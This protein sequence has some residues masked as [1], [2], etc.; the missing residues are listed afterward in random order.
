MKNLKEIV[1]GTKED[2]EFLKQISILGVDPSYKR[3]GFSVV[4]N[5]K[6][7]HVDS[8]DFKSGTYYMDSGSKKLKRRAIR[9]KVE[10]LTKKYNP[11]AIVIERVR[12]FSTSYVSL[13]TVIALGSL[14]STVVD[15]T[16]LDVF[17][18]DTRSMKATVVGSA[19][20][21]KKDVIDWAYRNFKV[22]TNDDE[23]DSIMIAS[24]AFKGGKLLKK[25]NF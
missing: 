8:I 4:K 10:E 23:A 9:E 5:D 18:A 22:K 12:L 15:A 13:A 24:Y 6:L 20:C 7:L 25:E 2:L 14:I 11:Y 3:T 19:K 17:S 1:N 21:K 16:D